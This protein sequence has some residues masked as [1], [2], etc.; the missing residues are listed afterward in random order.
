[1][2]EQVCLA[3]GPGAP[4]LLGAGRGCPLRGLGREGRSPES[5][6]SCICSP[7]CGDWGAGGVPQELMWPITGDQGV[8]SGRV[9]RGLSACTFVWGPWA[10]KSA[11]CSPHEDSC[12]V[13]RLRQ[14]NR[15]G[16]GQPHWE[17]DTHEWGCSQQGQATPLS[18]LPNILLRTP[19]PGPHQHDRLLQSQVRTCSGRVLSPPGMSVV[20]VWWGPKNLARLTGPHPDCSWDHLVGRCDAQHPPPPG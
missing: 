7:G 1:M 6:R 19:A 16:L 3:R 20:C 17:A 11:L 18:L 4:A 12:W 5:L 14:G 2:T 13:S 8:S 15:L 10:L 9:G